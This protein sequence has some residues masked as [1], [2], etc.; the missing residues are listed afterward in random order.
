MTI[1]YVRKRGPT[2]MAHQF[3]GSP[4][5]A[6]ELIKLLVRFE[7]PAILYD[8]NPDHIIIA[9]VGVAENYWVHPGDWILIDRATDEVMA[10][11]SATF[12]LE[13]DEE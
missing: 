3:D 13:Y 7:M 12:D 11:D 10:V 2:Y 6:A 9:L 4:E 1:Q 8:Q 5:C